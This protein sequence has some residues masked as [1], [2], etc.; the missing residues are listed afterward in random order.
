MGRSR[1]IME[2]DAVIGPGQSLRQKDGR[3]RPRASVSHSV[4]RVYVHDVIGR[5]PDGF[6]HLSDAS[7]CTSS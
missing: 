2:S 1:G 7:F 4:M 5:H 6:R 3:I